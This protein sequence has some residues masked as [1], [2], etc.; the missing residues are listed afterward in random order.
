MPSKENARVGFDLFQI[1][2]SE[3]EPA[4]GIA[5]MAWS[6]AQIR[7]NG[8]PGFPCYGRPGQERIAPADPWAGSGRLD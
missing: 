8:M 1:S 6:P 4:V 3:A 2:D 7:R 5:Y